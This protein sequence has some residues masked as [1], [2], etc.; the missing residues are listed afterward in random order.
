MVRIL[1]GPA[2]G[3][4]FELARAPIFLRLVHSADGWDALDQLEDEPRQDETVHV[5]RKVPGTEGVVFACGRGSGRS[6]RGGRYETGDYR[7][8]ED[9]N[10][11][12]MRETH[13][14]R[15]W[16]EDQAEAEGL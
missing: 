11:E 1:D 10:H 4:A 13:V 6:R 12:A 9:A 5:Y 7:H 16:C 15:Q 3:R 14:W 2:A 8:V